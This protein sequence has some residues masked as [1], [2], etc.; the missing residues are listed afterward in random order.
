MKRRQIWAPVLCAALLMTALSGTRYTA[1]ADEQ[2]G[3]VEEILLIRSQDGEQKAALTE[4]FRTHGDEGEKSEQ[5]NKEVLKDLKETSDTAVLIFG[6]DTEEEKQKETGTETADSQKPDAQAAASTQEG[7][8]EGKEAKPVEETKAEETETES[9]PISESQQKI[10]E[11]VAGEFEQVVVVFNNYRPYGLEMMNEY[12][13]IKTVTM[14][15]T[16]DEEE[17]L[18]AARLLVGIVSS[19]TVEPETAATESPTAV[20]PEV[21]VAEEEQ[22]VETEA[23]TQKKQEKE[24]PAEKESETAKTSNTQTVDTAKKVNTGKK[25]GRPLGDVNGDGKID[26]QDAAALM[27]LDGQKVTEEMLSYADVTGDGKINK[28][29]VK[30]LLKYISGEIAK[31]EVEE[32]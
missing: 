13:S 24:T 20:Q 12:A 31:F 11:Q 23:E 9:I 18:E 32:K 22:P 10:I 3:E 16:S 27:Q 4:V 14:I 30:Q 29:D 1:K 26:S 5:L 6:R 21:P 17:M 7:N 25:Q 28:K 8:Q 15:E 19:D 2:E